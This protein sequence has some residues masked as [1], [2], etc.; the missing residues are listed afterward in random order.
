MAAGATPAAVDALFDWIWVRGHAG[1][2]IEALAPLLPLLGLA[3]AALADATARAALR[4][5]TDGALGAGVFGVPTLAI[6]GDLFWGNDAHDFA[7]AALA[8]PGLLRDAWMRR[9]GTL[10]VGI[11]RRDA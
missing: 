7:L 8:D 5:N 4:R 2:S 9:P 10:P 1:D 3:P 6:G 11:Q